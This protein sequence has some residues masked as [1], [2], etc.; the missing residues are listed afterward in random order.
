[1]LAYTEMKNV[2]LHPVSTYFKNEYKSDWEFEYYQFIAKA[3]ANR[4]S[5]WKRMKNTLSL[6]FPTEEQLFERRLSECK[7]HV[8]VEN[9]L[10][11][12]EREQHRQNFL[13]NR[14]LTNMAH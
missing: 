14:G 1:M 9:M 10:K 3:K 11:Q 8:E 5:I 2:N 4:P 6:A 12:R 13:Q 7:S